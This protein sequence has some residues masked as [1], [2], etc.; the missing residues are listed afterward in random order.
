MKDAWHDDGR[1][2]L[3]LPEELLSHWHGVDAD[4]DKACAAGAD[5]LG[6]IPVAGGV[7]LVLGDEP[8]RA[9]FAQDGAGVLVLIRWVCAEDGRELIEFALRG[10]AVVDTQPDVCFENHHRGWALFD[11][12][13]DPVHDARPILRT[14]LP[15][16]FLRVSTAVLQAERNSAVV[17]HFYAAEAAKR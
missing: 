15:L 11:A 14:E 3:L 16:G 4:Y 10:E 6:M 8:G 7:G 17:H 9:T 12:A 5:W 2:L 1:L 13:A